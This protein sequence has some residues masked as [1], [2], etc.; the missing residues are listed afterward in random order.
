MS[1]AEVEAFEKEFPDGVQHLPMTAGNIA[2]CYNVP[3]GP[4]DLKLSRD[5]YVH[6][7]LG[8]ITDWNDPA[9]AASNPGATL[10]AL[11]ITVVRR[12]EGSGTTF[13]FTSHLAAVNPKEWVGEE[14]KPLVGK[15]IKW[16]V[17]LGAKGNSGVAA[18]IQQTPGAIGYLEF[19]YAELTKLPD[20]SPLPIARLENK[21]GRYVRPSAQSGLAALEKVALPAN[22]CP[23]IPD[24]AD[25]DA[26]PIVTYTWLL[27]HKNYHDERK[28]KEVRALLA[29]CLTDGQELAAELGYIP[30]PKAVAQK[31]LKAAE[32]IAP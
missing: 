32:A 10:P 19:G 21:A 30:L 6:I 2:V 29:Y 16:P 7:Y 20:G 26:Y 12:A 15:S 11:P 24:P 4:A 25:P 14:G 23:L 8:T 1:K 5:A 17:G 22:L 28:A 18:L 9:I 3:G 31:V 13:A 27:C